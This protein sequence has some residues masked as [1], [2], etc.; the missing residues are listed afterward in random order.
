MEYV[1]LMEL[2]C[3]HRESNASPNMTEMEIIAS[4]D[5]EPDIAVWKLFFF[6]FPSEESGVSSSLCSKMNQVMRLKLIE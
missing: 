5:S 4:K 2:L 1:N 6:F 3:S